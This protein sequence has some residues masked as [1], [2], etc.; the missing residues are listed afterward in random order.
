MY[1]TGNDGTSLFTER[2][3]GSAGRR[4]DLP[5]MGK[6]LEGYRVMPVPPVDKRE[7]VGRNGHMIRC[8]DGVQVIGTAVNEGKMFIQLIETTDTVLQLPVP[9]SPLFLMVFPKR[10]IHR[11]FYP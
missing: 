3:L 1:E 6:T 4:I 10:F 7:I 9:A 2:V 5:H 11:I 8:D